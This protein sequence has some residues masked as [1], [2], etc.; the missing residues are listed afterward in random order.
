M[1]SKFTGRAG[2]IKVEDGDD[3]DP[4]SG[5]QYYEV[6]RGPKAAIIAKRA[7]FINNGWKVKRQKWTGPVYQLQAT[8]GWIPG[9]GN[10]SGSEVPVDRYRITTELAQLDLRS[11]PKLIAS[12]GSEADL[13]LL[14]HD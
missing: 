5:W 8:A 4:Q 13:A 7:P 1:A 14:I 10:G 12:A 9:Q 3:F 6:W 2:A 11:N